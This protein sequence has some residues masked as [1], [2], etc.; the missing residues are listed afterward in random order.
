MLQDHNILEPEETLKF[1][2]VKAFAQSHKASERQNWDGT[3]RI[4]ETKDR[5]QK[6]KQNKPEETLDKTK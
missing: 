6:T 4:K 3:S 5:K 2:E 1:K